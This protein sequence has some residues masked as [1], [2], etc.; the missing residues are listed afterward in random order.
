[1]RAQRARTVQSIENLWHRDDILF[2]AAAESA[3]AAAIDLNKRAIIA[4]PGEA[5]PTNSPA[6]YP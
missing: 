6:A 5:S 1:M 2:R 4:L 3:A